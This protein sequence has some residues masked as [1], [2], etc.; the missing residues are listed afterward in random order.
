[1]YV[2]MYVCMYVYMYVCMYVCVS[3]P[4][5]M[6]YTMHELKKRGSEYVDYG[7]GMC[8]PGVNAVGHQY[9]AILYSTKL[10]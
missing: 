6:C 9:K 1:M 10:W 8:M 4:C 2:C 3:V 7:I 5:L